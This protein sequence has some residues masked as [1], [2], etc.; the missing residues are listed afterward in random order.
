MGVRNIHPSIAIRVLL[1]TYQE[2]DVGQA[3]ACV[4]NEHN[5]GKQ[6]RM[7]PK[8]KQSFITLFDESLPTV[9]EHRL[10]KPALYPS[11]TI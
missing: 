4:R 1:A 5:G 9:V 10:L 8:R 7:A 6:L 11:E 2:L 3:Q